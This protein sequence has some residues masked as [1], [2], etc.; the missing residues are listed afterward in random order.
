MNKDIRHI[1]QFFIATSI[2][3]IFLL[4]SSLIWNIHEEKRTTYELARVE[5]IGNH[6][7][8]LTFRRW[9]AMHGGVYV[10]VTEH[11]KPNEY[12]DF[13]PE[14]DITTAS[15]QKLTLINPAYMTRLAFEL[16]EEQTGEKG[17]ITSLDPLRP[18]NNPD[19]WESKAL[20]L[21]KTGVKD[22]SSIEMIDN[23]EYLRY[24]R[25][26]VVEEGCIKCHESQNYK[27]GDIYGG[28][29]VAIPMEKYAPILKTKIL[30]YAYSHLIIAIVGIFLG[31]LAY[32]RTLRSVKERNLS[33][34]K[35]LANETLLK[36]KNKELTYAKEK[37]EESDRLKTIFLQNMSHEIRTPM[38]AILGFSSLI[39]NEFDN[40]RKLIEYTDI[41][42][43]R[44][45]DLL[46]ILNDLLDISR[47][48]SEKI[49]IY[50]EQFG[51]KNF[52]MELKAIAEANQSRFDKHHIQILVP[53]QTCAENIS[54]NT[55]KGKLNQIFSN[56][57]S[58]AF[59]FTHEGNIEIGYK[60][61]D[62]DIHFF[63]SDTGIG[64]PKEELNHVFERFSQVDQSISR[65]HEG[66]GL[67]LS[68]VKGLITLLNGS[69]KVESTPGMGSK[70]SFSIP[71]DG[72]PLEENIQ[73]KL[74]FE[75]H[76]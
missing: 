14:R 49:E 32:R 42:N 72:Y 47:I 70:F 24:M 3:F 11:I 30:D 36:E 15:G 5:A 51:L 61:I 63:V 74:E 39:P 19:E 64:I 20:H 12:L 71:I 65:Q 43:Q 38:N 8:D 17:H 35:V 26:M 55:D 50:P 67:G 45:N 60:I 6:N 53:H 59:K 18:E 2:G 44:G 21:F 23:K 56:L 54:L 29:S 62:Q 13:I 68:I 46:C 40:R 37:A 7:K 66:T 16:A 48:E 4:A 52:L 27:L 76:S 69:I 75:A 73:T 22:Y 31:W 34:E 1:K 28:I 33:Q 57:I 9:A 25:P 10:P 41:I 58:N